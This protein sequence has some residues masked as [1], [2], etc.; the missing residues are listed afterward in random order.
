MI[1]SLYHIFQKNYILI[2]PCCYCNIFLYIYYSL[3]GYN[4]V[5]YVAFP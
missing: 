3:E 2:S 4:V 5:F 1:S